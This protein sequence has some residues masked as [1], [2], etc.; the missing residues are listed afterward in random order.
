MPD[1]NTPD[2]RPFCKEADEFISWVRGRVADLDCLISDHEYLK[3]HRRN[4]RIMIAV[5]FFDILQ[6]C[7]P[8]ADPIRMEG[9][10]IFQPEKRDKILREL[11][12]RLSLFF[13][14]PDQQKNS[15][16][17]IWMP[18][19]Y[20]DEF[21]S[22]L[23]K[24]GAS[25][26]E[27]KQV[28]KQLASLE[29]EARDKYDKKLMDLF[30]DLRNGKAPDDFLE[31]IIGKSRDLFLAISGVQTQG[32]ALSKKMF[33]KNIVTKSVRDWG[34][35]E[36]V[37][38]MIE[39]DG[40]HFGYDEETEAEWIERF[41]DE[42][43]KAGT[44]FRSS[45][46]VD[47]HT[48]MLVKHLNWILREEN[49]RVIYVSSAYMVDRVLRANRDRISFYRVD[50]KPIPETSFFRGLDVF[51]FYYRFADGD[52]S[53]INP[54]RIIELATAD[55][56]SMREVLEYDN[57]QRI[58]QFRGRRDYR[59][60]LE[61]PG[62]AEKCEG[63][64]Q[65][66]SNLRRMIQDIGKIRKQL[67]DTHVFRSSDLFEEY[68]DDT[69]QD[70]APPGSGAAKSDYAQ[71]IS[72]LKEIR[73]VSQAHNRS[74]YNT[75]SL[76]K[77]LISA[78]FR[79]W[80]AVSKLRSLGPTSDEVKVL[81]GNFTLFPFRIWFENSRLLDQI[82][83][84]RDFMMK[85]ENPP[86]EDRLKEFYLTLGNLADGCSTSSD[87]QIRFWPNGNKLTTLD[88]DSLE[89]RLAVAVLLFSLGLHQEAYNSAEQLLSLNNVHHFQNELRIIAVQARLREYT[90]TRYLLG[91]VADKEAAVR[92]I[93]ELCEGAESKQ[94]P[95]LLY[96]AGFAAGHHA[97]RSPK[98]REIAIR[99][100][101]DSRD[102]IDAMIDDVSLPEWKQTELRLLK[103]TALISLSYYLAIE[104]VQKLEPAYVKEAVG[105]FEADI[106]DLIKE[107]EFTAIRMHNRGFVYQAA[108]ELAITKE[109]F[110]HYFNKAIESYKSANCRVH[111]PALANRA[112]KARTD[113]YAKKL[114]LE[115]S[116]VVEKL[117]DLPSLHR[118][119]R[120]EFNREMELLKKA[121]SS[122]NDRGRQALGKLEREFSRSESRLV[123]DIRSLNELREKKE[124]SFSQG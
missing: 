87:E 77:S 60:C 5:D 105:Y 11:I 21:G 64:E 101:W 35:P 114:N 82:S 69:G 122:L 74:L 17:P 7:F 96:L 36:D 81:F 109:E 78:E 70:V 76:L 103:G 4:R 56:N 102:A 100:C 25:R 117:N 10:D 22:N 59:K 63:R 30:E 95:R 71:A 85:Q 1:A 61:N 20:E 67:F 88:K 73:N 113:G 40:E 12:G 9:A 53:N 124:R 116:E 34:L 66:D 92:E 44:Y 26:F 80:V 99:K 37:C 111:D 72:L 29:G 39:S 45:W 98:M 32:V 104:G 6:V 31:F 33:Q 3:D 57:E 62:Y 19:P 84:L 91:S 43:R 83:K 118:K 107:D 123:K 55:R 16:Y 18:F 86:S 49:T 110:E 90:E 38:N 13:G 52:R 120:P 54:E 97:R 41:R 108:A 89:R 28:A 24:Y 51:R 79:L 46:L 68:L 121:W 93:V 119:S 65:I 23:A 8:Y 27:G 112:L 47:I 14:L 94:D 75:V 2:C 50:G 15:Y 42:A 115:V 48:V 106:P 58:L